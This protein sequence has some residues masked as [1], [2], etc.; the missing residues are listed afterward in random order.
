MK[1][2][3]LIKD[4]VRLEL[5]KAIDDWVL[6]YVIGYKVGDAKITEVEIDEERYSCK[7]NE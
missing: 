4:E 1:I 2:E 5:D 6:E 7:V 3:D